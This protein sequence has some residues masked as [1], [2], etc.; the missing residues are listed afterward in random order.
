M[1]T[2]QPLFVTFFMLGAILFFT[3]LI[4]RLFLYWRGNWDLLAFVKGVFSTLFSSRM[5][6]VIKILFLDGILQRRLIS[7]DKLRWLMKVLIMI[8]YPGILIAGHLKMEM[9]HQ[10]ESF[11]HL[12]RFFYAPFCDF[13]FFRDVTGSS[14]GFSDALFAISFDLFGAMILTGEFIAVYRRFIVKAVTF[15]TSIGDI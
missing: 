7:Q 3:G 9:M 12:I 4:L 2:G 1:L 14:L 11:P 13:Y 15:K 5:V 6:K 8:G 10:F